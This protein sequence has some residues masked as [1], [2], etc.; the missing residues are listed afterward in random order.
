MTVAANVCRMS[1]ALLARQ[2]IDA[3]ALIQAQSTTK[4]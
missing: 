3:R 4:N 2:A 1:S